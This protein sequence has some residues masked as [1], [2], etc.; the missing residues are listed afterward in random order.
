MLT[1]DNDPIPESGNVGDGTA[2]RL[3]PFIPMVIPKGKSERLAYI[4]EDAKSSGLI[5]LALRLER[6]QDGTARESLHSEVIKSARRW[7]KFYG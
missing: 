2:R 6:C 1:P 5:E 7:E 3:N 4:V